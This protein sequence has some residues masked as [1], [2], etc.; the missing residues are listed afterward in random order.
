VC[1]C[2]SALPLFLET[3]VVAIL[4]VDVAGLDVVTDILTDLVRW[5]IY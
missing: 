3:N 2:L 1:L 5:S 4:A